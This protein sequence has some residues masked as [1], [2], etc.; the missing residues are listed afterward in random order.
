MP[1]K[2][3]KKPFKKVV[4]ANN[5]V[6]AVISNSFIKKLGLNLNLSFQIKPS[7]QELFNNSTVIETD[8]MYDDS[9]SAYNSNLVNNENINQSMIYSS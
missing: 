3:K 4:M 1:A 9:T 6:E 2:K 5:K 7:S 8:S